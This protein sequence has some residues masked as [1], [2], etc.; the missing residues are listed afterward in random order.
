M[1]LSYTY[2]TEQQIKSSSALKV[3]NS[4]GYLSQ[5]CTAATEGMLLPLTT[6]GADNNPQGEYHITQQWNSEVTMLLTHELCT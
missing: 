4:V 5:G 1:Q 3:Q 2:H 6:S